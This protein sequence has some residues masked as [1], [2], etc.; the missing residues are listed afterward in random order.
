MLAR[1]VAFVTGSRESGEDAPDW[2]ALARVDTVV[3]YMGGRTGPPSAAQASW[4]G[5]A[6]QRGAWATRRNPSMR[7]TESRARS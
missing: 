5:V 2:A 3:I 7:M 6:P 4:T 1:S